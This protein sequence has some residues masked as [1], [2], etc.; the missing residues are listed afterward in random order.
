MVL[1]LIV[2]CGGAES[3]Q[4]WEAYDVALQEGDETIEVVGTIKLL[5]ETE[6]K[7]IARIDYWSSDPLE[8]SAE[9]VEADIGVGMDTADQ[10][11][12]FLLASE[13]AWDAHIDKRKGYQVT[14]PVCA[15]ITI[16][17]SNLHTGQDLGCLFEPAK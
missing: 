9:P 15:T 13:E 11:Q 8:N 5:K 1:A 17:A 12:E 16:S 4:P 14:A 7:A 10:F 3:E 6:E 2:A